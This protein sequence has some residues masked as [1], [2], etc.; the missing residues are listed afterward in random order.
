MSNLL[1]YNNPA[2]YADI[3]FSIKVAGLVPFNDP[4][5]EGEPVLD[6]VVTA[7]DAEYKAEYFDGENTYVCTSLF[8]PGLPY[9]ASSEGFIDYADLT[10][11]QIISW[12]QQQPSF[13]SYKHSLALGIEEQVNGNTGLALPWA[14]DSE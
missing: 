13:E 5:Q 10:E 6:G 2:F 1:N 8:Q 3:E 14:S 7:V 11:E 4:L 9:P 12:L